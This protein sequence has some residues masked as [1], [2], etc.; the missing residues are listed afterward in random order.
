[1]WC[2]LHSSLLNLYSNKVKL[3]KFHRA[4]LPIWLVNI[5]VFPRH[6][7]FRVELLH[8]HR[9]LCRRAVTVWINRRMSKYLEPRQV[10]KRPWHKMISKGKNYWI[11]WSM[12][13][14]SNWIQSRCWITWC[15]SNRWIQLVHS[16]ARR[17]LSRTLRRREWVRHLDRI[18]PRWCRW[19]KVEWRLLGVWWCLPVKIC[20]QWF[21]W[22]NHRAVLR[23]A[24]SCQMQQ[25]WCLKVCFLHKAWCNLQQAWC[26]HLLAWCHRPVWCRQLEWCHLPEWCLLK[27]WCNLQEAWCRRP[28]WWH[29]PGWWI[30]DHLQAWSDKC[31]WWMG[32][33]KIKWQIKC[34]CRRWW[35]VL[36]MRRI[37]YR[38]K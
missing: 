17:E 21:K 9:H 33:C 19:C 14:V 1:M 27:E 8:R 2:H 36:P 32:K 6:Q 31:K 30:K 22:C 20:R 15:N 11:N 38:F 37:L 23:Q 10:M 4:S 28:E 34:K 3:Y 13:I 16:P 7:R 12:P 24:W 35:M 26:N 5:R 18:L 25:L 29:H